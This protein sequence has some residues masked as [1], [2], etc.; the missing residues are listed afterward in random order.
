VRVSI[1][2]GSLFAVLISLDNLSLSFFFDTAQSNTLP[3]VML[4]RKWWLL[5]PAWRLVSLSRRR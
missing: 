4:R 1:F 2:A 5:E 3:L